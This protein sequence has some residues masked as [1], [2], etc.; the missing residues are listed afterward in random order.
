MNVWRGVLNELLFSV[1]YI[2]DYFIWLGYIV[3]LV[4]TQIEVGRKATVQMRSI[5]FTEKVDWT[6]YIY[7]IQITC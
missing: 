4:E 3:E 2:N 7:T 6:F 1:W 5:S